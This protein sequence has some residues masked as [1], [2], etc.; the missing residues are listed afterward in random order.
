MSQYKVFSVNQGQYMMSSAQD[1]VQRGHI[2][3]SMAQS[4]MVGDISKFAPV[5][6]Y[7]HYVDNLLSHISKMLPAVILAR[8]VPRPGMAALSSTTPAPSGTW[9]SSATLHYLAGLHEVLAEAPAP[10]WP[11]GVNSLCLANR[12]RKVGHALGGWRRGASSKPTA[13]SPQVLVWA[14]ATLGVVLMCA[15]GG[16]LAVSSGWVGDQ[17]WQVQG[18]PRYGANP[19]ANT[20]SG[21][22]ALWSATCPAASW[23]AAG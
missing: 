6:Q 20:T 13:P 22:L 9:H 3:F 19:T 11:L 7:R 16:I 17:A 18:H 8:L 5:D 15:C 10:A 2:K 1:L 21:L 4:S 23:V 12:K 14:L